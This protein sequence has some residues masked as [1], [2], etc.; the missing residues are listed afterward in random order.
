M[1]FSRGTVFWITIATVA[2]VLLVLLRQILLPFVVGMML[3]YLLTPIVSTL[4]RAGINRALA[5]LTITLLI[6][7][8][9]AAFILIMLPVLDGEVTAFVQ[10][11]PS[12]LARMQTLATEANR[13]WLRTI[14]GHE[15]PAKQSSAQIW[16]TVGGHSFDDILRFLW[17]GGNALL[18]FVSLLVVT[19]IVA[20]Y[21]TIDWNRMIT[22]IESW[23]LPQHRDEVR[24]LG[25][26]INDAVAGFVRGQAVICIVLCVLYATALRSIGLHHGI[27]IGLIA[28]LI[29]FVPYLGAGTGFV[30]SMSVAVA[31]FWPNWLPIMLVGGTFLVGEMLADYVLTPRIIGRRVKLSPVWLMFALFAFG[32]LFGFIGLL[33]ALPLTAA[34]G[35]LLRFAMRKSG[36][37]APIAE[38]PPFA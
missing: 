27:A 24:A 31:Q 17:S 11:F 16:T 25:C 23:I 13:P 15:L 10:A 6:V 14:L 21:L 4:E 9:F 32:S 18:S 35:V 1:R 30:V 2:L 38:T 37:S 19:P 29:S 3:A 33:L 5:T 36:T 8:G 34:L 7:T 20:I 12:Y 26:E 22:T 28:G